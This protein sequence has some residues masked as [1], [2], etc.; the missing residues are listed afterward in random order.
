MRRA[1][2]LVVLA[3]I[4]LGG[5]VAI[6]SMGVHRSA[7]AQAEAPAAAPIGAADASSASETVVASTGIPAPVR[8]IDAI[9]QRLQDRAAGTFIGDIL[10]LRDSNIARWVDRRD[11]PVT[12]WIED[13]APLMG[14]DQS[15]AALVR[16]AFIDWGAAGVPLAFSF[17]GDSSRA[18][19]KV[20]LVDRF[21]QARAGL[22]IWTRDPNWWIIGGSIQ[23]ALHSGS[24]H[25]LTPDQ[26]HAIALHEIGHLLGLDHTRDTLAIMAPR[27][28]ALTLTPQDVATMR[29]IYELPPGTVKAAR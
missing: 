1:D 2:L 10:A 14:P 12:V 23:L 29:L 18:E 16:S 25:V 7:P 21:E 20:T 9:R 3:V 28:R 27:V 19:V 4:A 24:G 8:N 26:F 22:T 6:Q 5:F 13:R 17:V 15:L 11:K